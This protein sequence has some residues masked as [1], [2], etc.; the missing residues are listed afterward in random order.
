VIVP[1]HRSLRAA[2]VPLALLAS[3][4]VA[5]P[6]ETV[7]ARADQSVAVVAAELDRHDALR[8]RGRVESDPLALR[9]ELLQARQRAELAEA[10]ADEARLSALRDVA[11]AWA[12]L[13]EVELQVRLAAAS[14]DLAERSLAITQLRFERGSATFLDV[15]SASTDLLD[16]ERALRMAQDGASLARSDLAGITGLPSEELGGDAPLDRTRFEGL[17]V[18][19][20]DVL[21]RAALTVPTLLRL[22]QGVELATLALELLDP[23]FAPRRQID[24]AALQLEQATAGEREALR[25]IT[26]RARSLANALGSALE[27]D[28]IA[29]EALGH[30]REREEV[31]RRRLDA[32]LVAEIALEAVRLQTLQAE[33]RAL[34]AEH[35]VIDAILALQAG[36]RY[37]VE[38][39]HAF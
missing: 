5:Q 6:L 35:A 31:E 19:P 21:G 9:P 25:G 1:L 14:R 18:P 24:E 10:E 3:V 27:G 39:W 20:A 30:A 28:R 15:Q 12:R 38:G 23:S 11:A 26:L 34:Q 17:E 8:A 16:A 2:L 36:T 13:R 32:G 33:L 7:L 29:Q 4:A 37:R 22:Q